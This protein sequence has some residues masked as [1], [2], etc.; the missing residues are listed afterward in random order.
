M[1]I[2]SAREPVL[3]FGGGGDES[4][5]TAERTRDPTATTRTT[6]GDV[7]KEARCHDDARERA[8]EPNTFDRV[9]RTSRGPNRGFILFNTNRDRSI[10]ASRRASAPPS[11]LFSTSQP[12]PSLARPTPSSPPPRVAR[13]R[14][15]PCHPPRLR[16]TPRAA[17]PP[18]DPRV[19]RGGIRRSP[20]AAATT[21]ARSR[22]RAAAA[23]SERQ[24]P[25]REGQDPRACACDAPKTGVR[26][27]CVSILAC[28]SRSVAQSSAEISRISAAPPS[29]VPTITA[30]PKVASDA[31]NVV[32]SVFVRRSSFSSS[33]S[34]SRLESRES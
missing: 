19:R 23:A 7:E 32:A 29:L 11:A 21:R 1:R 17:P 16:S 15:L 27:R 8:S 9:D 10:R 4:T 28:T 6:S 5:Q 12:P 25:A 18:E 2:A 24:N 26:R 33:S 30:G 14:T 22:P 3:A 20:P 31:S 34:S 13:A